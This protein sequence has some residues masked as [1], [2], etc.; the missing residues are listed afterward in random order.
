[1]YDHPK[2]SDMVMIRTY[3]A[4]S[5]HMGCVQMP[6]RTEFDSNALTDT[7]GGALNRRT[8]PIETKIRLKQPNFG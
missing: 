4:H 7:P 3:I 2:G 6:I 1:M 5:M 8:S